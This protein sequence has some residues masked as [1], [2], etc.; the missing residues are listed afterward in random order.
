MTLQNQAVCKRCGQ[1]M[2]LVANIAPTRAESG[3]VA[4]TAV[5]QKVLWSTP[6]TEVGRRT[7]S[8]LRSK[9]RAGSASCPAVRAT[10]IGRS[11]PATGP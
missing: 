3:L 5:R 4:P 9:E 11:S 1:G 10:G 8:I 7:M 6:E 2:E